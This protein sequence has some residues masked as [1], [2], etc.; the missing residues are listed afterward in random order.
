MFKELKTIA[1]IRPE[2]VGEISLIKNYLDEVIQA[3]DIVVFLDMENKKNYIDCSSDNLFYINDNFFDNFDALVSKLVKERQECE[4]INL[5]PRLY[6]FIDESYEVR[7]DR[8]FWSR[9]LWLLEY[10][11]RLNIELILI[12][13]DR[14]GLGSLY[15]TYAN[16]SIKIR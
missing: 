14:E 13:K 7:K 3:K 2:N 15:N 4:D 11:E 8:K 10:K 5:L 1:M 9:I 6:I 16:T 12:S